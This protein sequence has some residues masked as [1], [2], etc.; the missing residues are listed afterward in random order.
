MDVF[1]SPLAVLLRQVRGKG[2]LRPSR[3]RVNPPLLALLHVLRGFGDGD[4]P[5]QRSSG[6][7]FGIFLGIHITHDALE[8]V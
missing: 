8:G 7:C 4:C 5:R 2:L 3:C 6:A 1:R